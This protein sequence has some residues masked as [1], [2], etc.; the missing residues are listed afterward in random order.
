MLRCLAYLLYVTPAENNIVAFELHVVMAALMLSVSSAL[1]VWV[2]V[3]VGRAAAAVVVALLTL[4]AV[5]ANVEKPS[6]RRVVAGCI[7]MAQFKERTGKECGGE[8]P[9]G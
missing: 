1:S 2:T 7:V 9:M 5:V 6:I 4:S 3:Q 8:E